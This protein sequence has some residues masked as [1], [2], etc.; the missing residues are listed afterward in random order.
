MKIESVT[1]IADSDRA[2]GVRTYADSLGVALANRGVFVRTHTHWKRDFWVA[3]RNIGAVALPLVSRLRSIPESQVTHATFGNL[4]SRK[5]GVVTVMDLVWRGAG[6]AESQVLH[7]LYRNKIRDNVV[8]CPTKVV[9][10]QVIGWSNAARENVFVTHLAPGEDFFTIPRTKKNHR[11]TVLMVGDA[12]PRK[13]TLESVKALEGLKVDLVHVGRPWGSTAYG[14]ECILEAQKRGVKRVE[15]GQ[16]PTNGIAQVMNDADVLLYPSTDEGFGL[17]PVEAAACGLTSVVGTHPV[18]D[19]VMGDD[20]Y[21]ADGRRPDKI[22]EGIQAALS[23]PLPTASL[24]ARAGLYSWDRC[25]KETIR[26]Y[27]ATL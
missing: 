18:F 16:I 21:K 15:L 4:M 10:E 17:P 12:N 22:R 23:S 5:C 8:I 19:E 26:A 20:A 24:T 14:T 9:A 27:E 1:L 13:R 11:P 2:V 3:G 25:A 6:Y 7:R